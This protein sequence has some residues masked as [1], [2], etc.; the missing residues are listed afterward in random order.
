MLNVRHIHF[1][2]RIIHQCWYYLSALKFNDLHDLLASYES[3]KIIIK[4]A[5][6]PCIICHILEIVLGCSGRGIAYRQCANQ[7]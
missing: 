7:W 5:A 1:L 6:P 4:V 3:L 2:C